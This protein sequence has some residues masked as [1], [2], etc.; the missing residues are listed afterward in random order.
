[1]S[2]EDTDSGWYAPGTLNG[3]PVPEP[4]TFALFGAALGAAWFIRRRR[5]A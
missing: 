4:G 5:S 2:G 1:M 3:D